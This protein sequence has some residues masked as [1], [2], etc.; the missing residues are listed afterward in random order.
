[1]AS[2]RHQ[3]EYQQFRFVLLADTEDTTVEYFLRNENKTNIRTLRNLIR[4]PGLELQNKTF[5]NEDGDQVKLSKIQVE[6]LKALESYE[7]N[8]QN[9]YGPP[10]IAGYFDITTTTRDDFLSFIAK[11]PDIENNP[12]LPDIDTQIKA[13]ELRMR[14][15]DN[16]N[17]NNTRSRN[18]SRGSSRSRSPTTRR[19]VNHLLAEFRKKKRP[20]ADYTML[21][22]DVMQWSEW[23]RQLRALVHT[24]GVEDVLNHLYSPVPGSDEEEVFKEMQSHLYPVFVKLVK[25]TKGLQ[26]VKSH[27]D[28]KDAQAIY[29]E[30]SEYYAGEASQMAIANLDEMENSIMMAEIPEVRRQALITSMQKYLLKID[31][32]NKLA[33]ADRQMNDA[34]KLTNLKRLIRNVPELENINSMV[35]VMCTGLM[36]RN[37]TPTP[38]EKIQMYLSVATMVDKGIKAANRGRRG[39]PSRNIHLT[40]ILGEDADEYDTDVPPLESNAHEGLPDGDD[41]VEE[42][43]D[44]DMYRAFATFMKGLKMNQATWDRLSP[45]A[46]QL[47]DQFDQ[48]DKNIILGSRPGMSP[49]PSGSTPQGTPS[50]ARPPQ[51]PSAL[52]SPPNRQQAEFHENADSVPT[53]G[54]QYET[55][56]LE[57]YTVNNATQRANDTT[58]ALSNDM[59][60]KPKPSPPGECSIFNTITSVPR[61]TTP[62]EKSSPA[63][64]G[65]NSGSSDRKSLFRM[66]KLRAK[67]AV[68]LHS[69]TW[70]DYLTEELDILDSIHRPRHFLTLH[71]RIPR[72]LRH[73]FA[74]D[75]GRF[76]VGNGENAMRINILEWAS[77]VQGTVSTATVAAEVLSH[78]V[79][80]TIAGGR[81]EVDP[82]AWMRET[83]GTRGADGE[84]RNVGVGELPDGNEDGEEDNMTKLSTVDGGNNWGVS[85]PGMRLLEYVVPERR[86]DLYGFQGR[87]MNG[88]PICQA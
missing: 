8:C 26:I 81:E 28:D 2:T 32:F 60:Y 77:K 9:W 64:T 52:R 41:N 45:E 16:N 3:L 82:W 49:S 69:H 79:S 73:R 37:H 34:Q 39:S 67:M 15:Q 43:I 5:P 14:I 55:N 88:M 83:V 54:N 30:L 51:R 87:V 25:E 10:E 35:T 1:M 23:D 71:S 21:L 57:Q 44:M 72:E 70:E 17:N 13:Y 85:G 63:G 47:W 61:V 76:T 42:V 62:N 48:K 46:H 12:V 56:F 19:V 58:V 11:H 78:E 74:V 20:Q 68:L 53:I 27:Q 80:M 6:E 24:H 33:S 7:T 18:N 66:P 40:E 31:D 22:E 84:P 75:T 50:S 4:K 36:G 29:K 59:Y 38:L 65:E 86:A